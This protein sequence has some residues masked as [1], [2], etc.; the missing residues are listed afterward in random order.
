MTVKRI[1]KGCIVTFDGL[2]DW[3]V[4]R[5]YKTGDVLIKRG[6]YLLGLNILIKSRTEVVKQNEI[7]L[8]AKE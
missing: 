7:A 2:G 3:T 1:K 5:V 8:T 4:A 6:Q